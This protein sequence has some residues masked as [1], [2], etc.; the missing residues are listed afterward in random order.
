[1]DGPFAFRHASTKAAALSAIGRGCVEPNQA[2]ASGLQKQ[3]IG[4]K[5][6]A[7]SHI[8]SYFPASL[9][10]Q[11]HAGIPRNA[12]VRHATIIVGQSDLSV[13]GIARVLDK[14]EFKVIACAFSVGHLAPSDLQGHKTILL[15]LD[16]GCDVKNALQQL[17]AFRQ[18]H[19]DPRIAVLTRGIRVADVASLLQAGANACFDQGIPPAIF[20]KSLELVMLGETFLSAAKLSLPRE[21][22]EERSPAGPLSLQELKVLRYLAEGQPNKN[23]ARKLGTAGAN[24]RS[25]VKSILDKIGVEN[26]TQAAVWA[27]RSGLLETSKRD[28]RH[29][30]EENEI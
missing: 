12:N 19:G 2:G 30:E 5:R 17:K 14:T 22:T 1:V 16:N 4:K 24:V 3:K 7:T 11:R 8:P 23:I 28:G 15:I 10:A 13:E 18:L 6:Q 27:M 21:K 26:R 9:P 25:R 29:G 20:L